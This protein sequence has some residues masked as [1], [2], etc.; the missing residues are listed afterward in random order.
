MDIDNKYGMLDIQLKILAI[1]KDIHAF[2]QDRGIIYS[3][4]RGTLLGAVRENGFIPWDDDIDIM[5]DRENF[6]KFLR[7]SV[8]L[9]GY[10][11]SR[12]L[13]IYRIQKEEDYNGTLTGAIIDIFVVDK[14][15]DSFFLKHFKVLL[16]KILQGMMKRHKDYKKYDFVK[17][18]PLMI[19]YM[20]GLLFSDSRKFKW[21]DRVSKIGK[22]G[23]G[24]NVGVYNDLFRY[25]SNEYNGELMER[26]CFHRFEDTQLCIT[27]EYHDY[28][29]TSYG[30]YM[31]PPPVEERKPQ[32]T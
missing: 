28:L 3:L 14:V 32:H 16:L 9:E 21:Y 31:I 13:W 18:I 25:L 11:V 5:M 10:V 27:E 12:M 17:R 4:S 1:M 8:C 2:F 30:D 26:I 6:E 7:E 15:P 23:T 19:T 22:Y 29:S 20:M 24:K